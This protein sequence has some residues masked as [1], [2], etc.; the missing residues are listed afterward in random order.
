MR[1]S[2]AWQL[3][4][5]FENG[6]VKYGDNNWK[7]GQPLSGYLDSGLRHA[8]NTLDLQ[9]DEDTLAQRRAAFSPPPPRY[10]QGVLAKYARTV[11]SASL[12][13]TTAVFETP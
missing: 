10:T 5:H 4:Q 6:A 1:G 9:V 8:F 11:S 3:D 12:G 2:S 13:A 7:L